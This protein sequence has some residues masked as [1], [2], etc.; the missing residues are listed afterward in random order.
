MKYEEPNIQI[1]MLE[2][3]MIITLTSGDD[4][5]IIDWDKTVTVDNV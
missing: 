1:F 2:N 4:D 3:E 5:T